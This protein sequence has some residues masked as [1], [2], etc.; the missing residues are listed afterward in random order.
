MHRETGQERLALP[1][2]RRSWP[3]PVPAS[4][5]RTKTIGCIIRTAPGLL[6]GSVVFVPLKADGMRDGRP[7][8]KAS[9]DR[10]LNNTVRSKLHAYFVHH[11]DQMGT[12]TTYPLSNILETTLTKAKTQRLIKDYVVDERRYMAGSFASSDSSPAK[13]PK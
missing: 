3:S 5:I 10:K 8:A 7:L 6:R 12:A 11:I 13:A 2:R 1:I 9:F 4:Q